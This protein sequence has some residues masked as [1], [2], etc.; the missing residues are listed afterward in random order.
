MLAGTGNSQQRCSNTTRPEEEKKRKN[1]T[2]GE[3]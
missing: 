1:L 2:L 3:C